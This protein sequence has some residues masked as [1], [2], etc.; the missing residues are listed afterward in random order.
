MLH[1]RELRQWMKSSR[2]MEFITS[3]NPAE[4]G[5]H[6]WIIVAGESGGN[7]PEA[8]PIKCKGKTPALCYET[9]LTKYVVSEIRSRNPRIPLPH[10][11][12]S[13]QSRACQQA[14]F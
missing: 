12:G 2:S 1:L 11:R 3:S 14:V 13:D 6:S 5:R 4:G 7:G 9:R 10:G 8:V